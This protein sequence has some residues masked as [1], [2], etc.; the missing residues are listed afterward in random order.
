ML[1]ELGWPGGNVLNLPPARPPRFLKLLYP[2]FPDPNCLLPFGL[3]RS[4]QMDWVDQVVLKMQ[5]SSVKF[6]CFFYIYRY[7]VL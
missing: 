3:V 4:S 6:A 2:I 1:V 5:L 7:A